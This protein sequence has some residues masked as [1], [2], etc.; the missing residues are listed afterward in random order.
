MRECGDAAAD[1]F[2]CGKREAGSV[3]REAGSGTKGNS[4]YE[5]IIL[6]V[7]AF[8]QLLL[9][10]DYADYTDLGIRVYKR[11]RMYLWSAIRN[12]VLEQ[13]V[14]QSQRASWGCPA[15]LGRGRGKAEREG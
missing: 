8:G 5:G 15:V 4:H 9:I 13:A 6:C 2:L 3:K 11:M 1:F 12:E 10:T 14:I 7:N